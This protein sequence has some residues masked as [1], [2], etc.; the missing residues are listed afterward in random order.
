MT[1]IQNRVPG[2]TSLTGCGNV[3][4]KSTTC[5][6]DKSRSRAEV[7]DFDPTHYTITR[8]DMPSADTC[9]ILSFQKESA[10]LQRWSYRKEDRKHYHVV[11]VYR[12]TSGAPCVPHDFLPRQAYL[13]FHKKRAKP[14]ELKGPNG[15]TYLIRQG[16]EV[17][18]E[19]NGSSG[20]LIILVV[21][22][23]GVAKTTE[24]GAHLHSA[25]GDLD[26][27]RLGT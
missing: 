25:P 19:D 9:S 8:P 2:L 26:V 13:I 24:I 12:T 17:V 18:V 16:Q 7:V 21:I 20:R 4:L 15:M 27:E 3:G 14:S 11:N 1:C 5:Q 23:L 6:D 10:L 22:S